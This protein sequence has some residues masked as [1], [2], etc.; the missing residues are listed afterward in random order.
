M[1]AVSKAKSDILQVAKE[2]KAADFLNANTD[3]AEL[4]E[5]AW[6]DLEGVTDEWIE[7]VEVEKI[8][9]GGDPPKLSPQEL[10]AMIEG[11]MDCCTLGCCGELEH[12]MRLTDKWA[13]IKPRFWDPT[14]EK[15]G[16]TELVQRRH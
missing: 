2:M 12:V 15:P 16:N 11:K 3:P 6:L 7:S 5:R 9:G 10:V 4:T 13:L 8:A 14:S 1:P